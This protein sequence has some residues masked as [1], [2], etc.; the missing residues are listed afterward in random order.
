VWDTA[1]REL[2]SAFRGRE[3]LRIPSMR[4][5]QNAVM[6]K[7]THRVAPRESGKSE[8]PWERT[9]GYCSPTNSS[10]GTPY[11]LTIFVTVGM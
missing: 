4:T 6:A 10:K 1:K 5:S 2:I 11:A 9:G 7:F 8:R 3:L